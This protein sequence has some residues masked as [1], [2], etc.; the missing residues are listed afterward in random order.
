MY[1]PGSCNFE[2]LRHALDTHQTT[3]RLD[4]RLVEAILSSEFKDAGLS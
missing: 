4:W 1:N 2:G 3:A